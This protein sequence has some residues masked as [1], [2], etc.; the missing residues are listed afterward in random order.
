M[1]SLDEVLRQ[2][3]MWEE[4]S[5]DFYVRAADSVGI[6][7]LKVLFRKLAAEELK[8]KRILEDAN[9]AKLSQYTCGV[10]WFNLLD[11]FK[12][13]SSEA[14]TKAVKALEFAMDKEGRAEERYRHM[15]K[16][17]SNLVVQELCSQLAT[18]ENCHR[19]LLR[20]E[21][22]RLFQRGR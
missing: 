5:H 6:E 14:L 9:I 1:S 11:D 12:S 7:P 17:A 2:A 10:D 18:A 21:Y 13:Q 20:S 4:Y 22:E 3:I 19:S 15:G 16:E 8:H